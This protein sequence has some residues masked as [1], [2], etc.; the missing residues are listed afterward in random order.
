MSKSNHKV[1]S[2]RRTKNGT[3]IVPGATMDLPIS[4]VALSIPYIFYYK[5]GEFDILNV[6]GVIMRH[7][8]FTCHLA[9]VCMEQNIPM[10]GGIEVEKD[11]TRGFINSDEVNLLYRIRVQKK[12]RFN[13]KRK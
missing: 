3:C 11:V 2:V 7:C 9:T 1:V 6:Q 13:A 8:S 10:I 12:E 5:G 4:D